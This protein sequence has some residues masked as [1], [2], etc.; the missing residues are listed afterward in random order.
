MDAGIRRLGWRQEL[1]QWDV[2]RDQEGEMEIGIRSV[3]GGRDKEGGVEAGIRMV[4]WRQE[5]GWW[6]GGRDQEGGMEAG[7]RRV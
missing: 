2:G 1:V 6:G 7:I 5:S 4:G 3:G